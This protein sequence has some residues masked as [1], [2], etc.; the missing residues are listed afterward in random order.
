MA[1][2]KAG[3]EE[4]SS[5]AP[6]ESPEASQETLNRLK[7]VRASLGTAAGHALEALTR[8]KVQAVP[9][10]SLP[11]EPAVDPHIVHMHVLKG[12]T[13]NMAPVER[14]GAYFPGASRRFEPGTY[15]MN[16][17]D[18]SDAMV[19]DHPW[20]K[21]DLADGA[22]EDPKQTLQRMRELHEK[23]Q[24]DAANH[25]AVIRQVEADLKRHAFKE[26]MSVEQMEAFQREMNTPINQLKRAP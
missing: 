11:E 12:F 15:T 21:R 26:Q 6:D 19:L 8:P 24:R 23:A 22:I 5:S 18:P 16:R 17:R 13:L 2:S 10:V 1:K 4:V 25:A 9:T 20:I 3:T 7:A 14:N